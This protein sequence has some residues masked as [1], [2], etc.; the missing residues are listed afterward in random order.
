MLPFAIAFGIFGVTSGIPAFYVILMSA[1]VYAGLAQFVVV[2]MYTSGIDQIPLLIGFVML[3]NVRF[4][5]MGIS[6]LPYSALQP[7]WQRFLLAFGLSDEPYVVV[8]NRFTTKG[9]NLHYQV[10]AYSLVYLFWVLGTAIGCAVSRVITDP[11]ALG[12]D[13]A[14]CAAFLVMLFPRLRSPQNRLAAIVSSGSAVILH[15]AGLGEGA[16]VAASI[17]GFCTVVAV[18]NLFSTYVREA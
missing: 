15:Q 16:I 3:V 18:K 12:V 11:L 17:L 5:L 1:T 8:I 13:F 2:N 7:K 14:M 4:F 6:L 10:Y 9:Y